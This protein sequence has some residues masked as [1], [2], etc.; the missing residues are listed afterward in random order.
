MEKFSLLEMELFVKMCNIV[1]MGCC[2][3]TQIEDHS[4]FLGY[5]LVHTLSPYSCGSFTC[6]HIK[7]NGEYHNAFL[8]SFFVAN[9]CI[10]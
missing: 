4:L 7:C 3:F 8:I 10:I 2:L 9:I 6:N 5:P 1:I